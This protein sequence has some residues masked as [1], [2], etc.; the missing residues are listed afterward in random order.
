[1]GIV[2]VVVRVVTRAALAIREVIVPLV[3]AVVLTAVRAAAVV[4]VAAALVRA[5]VQAA[6][7]RVAEAVV[8]AAVPAVV[9]VAVHPLVQV[10]Q[11]SVRA[12]AKTL[13]ISSKK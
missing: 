7:V 11:D 3:E 8:R 5:A 10:V 12:G 9:R 6:A 2:R 1:M 4:R 13:R